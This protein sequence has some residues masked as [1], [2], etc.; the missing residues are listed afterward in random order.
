MKYILTIV[1]LFLVF[2]ASKGF[3]LDSKTI[4]F[5]SKDGLTVTA[6]TY[7][8][9]P[10][11]SL[12]IIL[13]HQAGWSRGEYNE[14]APKLNKL[15]FNCMAVDQRSGGAVNRVI[16]QTVLEAEKN[17]KN[18]TYLDAKQDIEASIK[19]VREKYKPKKLI[20]WG[21]SY[22]AALVLQIAGEKP[23]LV[24]GVLAFAPGE[25]F[26]SLGKSSTW[27]KD[28]SKNIKVPVF[29][30]SAKGEEGNWKAIFNLIESGDKVSF[31]PETKGNH[32]SRALW[33][34]FADSDDYWKAVNEFLKNYFI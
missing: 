23:N 7:I 2:I 11:S 12:F 18:T 8:T 28:S 32:G 15:G 20:I 5:P 9:N 29:I 16:N 14:I 19:Y 21:S 10:E 6:D 31:V 24:D 25:Y 17:K 13:F 30:T 3:A 1:S 33:S 4:T 34:E 26:I 22:S 27:V